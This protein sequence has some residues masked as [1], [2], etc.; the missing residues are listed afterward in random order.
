MSDAERR[1]PRQPAVERGRPGQD[2]AAGSAGG[3]I[4]GAGAAG[5]PGGSSD[6]TAEPGLASDATPGPGCTLDGLLARTDRID[7]YRARLEPARGS[8][9]PI[10]A[11]FLRAASPAAEEIARFDAER[12]MIR[13][14][15]VDGVARLAS[16]TKTLSGRPA[17]ALEAVPGEQLRTFVDG[18]PLPL[19]R[20]LSIAI[21]MTAI[22]G[23]LHAAGVTHKDLTPDRFL[24]D[25]RDS[26]LTLIDLGRATRLSRERLAPSGRAVIDGRPAYVSPE[27]TGRMNRPLDHRTDFYS[28][29][30]CFFEML[31]G[32]VPFELDDPLEIVHGHIARRPARV[33]TLNPDVPAAVG[34]I[35]ARLLEKSAHDRYQSA[36]GLRADLDRCRTQLVETHRVEPF[37]LGQDDVSTVL[38]IPDQL[39]GRDREVETLLAAFEHIRAGGTDFILV[40]GRSGI[41]KT[42]LVGEIHRP[43]A[44][45][46]GH[47]VEGRFDPLGRN[48]PY[49]GWIGAFTNLAHSLLMESQAELDAWRARLAGA[50]ATNGRVVTA[51]IPDLRLVVGPQPDV[52]NLGPSEM[53]NR[54]QRVFGEIVRALATPERPLVVF[55]DDLQWADQASLAL[56]ELLLA[57]RELAHVLIVGAY[58]DNELAPD[59]LLTES[60]ARIEK[61]GRP[62]TTIKVGSLRVGDVA[63]LL[64]DTLH[65]PIERTGE[66]ARLVHAKTDGNPWFIAGLLEAMFDSGLLEYSG[67]WQWDLE[68]VRL[69]PIGDDIADLMVGRIAG[70][71]PATM[72]VLKM[73]ACTGVEFDLDVVALA[74]GRSVAETIADLQPAFQAGI[75]EGSDRTGRFIHDRVSEATYNLISAEEREDLHH[76]IG[77]TLLT[78]AGGAWPEDLVFR[79]AEQFNASGSRLT[80]AERPIAFQANL[81]AGRRA[82]ASAAFEAA[83]RF[84]ARAAELLPENAWELDYA[85]TLA[86]YTDW[87]EAAYAAMDYG[88]AEELFALVLDRAAT[89][90]DRIRIHVA[91]IEYSLASMR[92]EEALEVVVTVIGELGIPFVP[93]AEIDEAA[94]AEQLAQFMANLGDRNPAELDRLPAAASPYKE[95]IEVL[96]SADPLLWL[97]YPG[98][99]FYGVLQG[100]NLSMEHGVCGATAGTLASLGSILCARGQVELGTAICEA[101]LRLL[102]RFDEPYR[103]AMVLLTYHNFVACWKSP[104]RQSVE[105]LLAEYYEAA[106]IG[107]NLGAANLIRDH[108]TMRL[109]SGEE[110]PS[111]AAAFDQFA[112]PFLRLNQ[113]SAA[114]TFSILRQATQVLCGNAPDP[115][116]LEGEFWSEARDLPELWRLRFSVAIATVGFA[117]LLI[118]SV[119]GDFG[120]ALEWVTRPGVEECRRSATG[121]YMEFVSAG[122]TALAYLRGGGTADER[123]EEHLASA[124]AIAARLRTA[125]EEYPPNFLPLYAL[126]AAEIARVKD[127]PWTAIRHY[128]QAIAAARGQE[129]PHLEGLANELAGLFWLDQGRDAYARP[130]LAAALSAYRRWGAR[131]KVAQ[132]LAQHPWLAAEARDAGESGPLDLRTVVKASQAISGEIELDRLLARLLQITIENAGAG[133]G[134]LLLRR[135]KSLIVA[136]EASSE[137]RAAILTSAPLESRTDVAHSIV[138][139]VVRSG[140]SVLLD[141]AANEGDFVADP[142]IAARK[143][144]SVLC[145]PIAL[146]GAL[147][148]VVYLENNL[149]AGAFGPDRL[150]VLEILCAQAAISLE[151]AR[152]YAERDRAA[153]ALRQSEEKFRTLVENTA[154][155]VFAMDT[156]GCF[157]YISPAI[158]ALSGY[159]PAEVVGRSFREFTLPEE[160]ARVASSFAAALGGT[161][162]PI[163]F[164]GLA[165]DGR[166]VHIRVSG[167]PQFEDGKPV[168]FTGIFTDISERRELQEQLLQAMKMESIGRLAGGVAHDF[169][170]LLTAILGNAELAMLELPPDAEAREAIAEIAKAGQRASSLTRQ[171]LAFASKQIVAP[172]RL[173]LSTVVSDS[174]R[175]LSRLLGE[176]IEI[177]TVLDPHLA[178][179]EAD[180]GQME[181]LL[182]NLTINARDA[183]PNGGHLV[184]ETRNALVEAGGPG[185]SSEV[186]PGP[187][188][189]LTV[190]DTGE[191]MSAET[192]SH[193]FEPF[194]TTKEAGKG[195]GLGLATCHGIV[196]QN[197][198]H[199]FVFSE[200]G[201]GSTFRIM[202][203]TASREVAAAGH[204][205]TPPTSIDGTETILV[206]E[207]EEQVR[208]LAVLGLRAH[209]YTVIEAAGG[210]QALKIVGRADTRLDLVVSDVVMPGMGGLE[211]ERRLARIRPAL[212]LI[213]ASGH[214]ETLV[215]SEQTGR[216]G[217]AFVQKPFTPEQLARKVREVLDATAPPESPPAEG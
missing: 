207:D 178:A 134:V 21:E 146:G 142:S 203:P 74:R 123:R 31:T 132:M 181:Q 48:I 86:L 205:Q 127:E 204:E 151:N 20:F 2:G 160:L 130:H 133:R 61:S 156:E 68:R 208:R 56:L 122:C 200:P 212:P 165:R 117:K 60:L 163:E 183:M 136:A 176:D 36:A 190:T 54:F 93:P 214:A 157:T 112:G 109:Q 216:G 78:A 1:P 198:G 174:E 169:N 90:T 191:G 201:L 82:R 184:I 77:R 4:G 96:A 33:E 217:V 8:A 89:L 141:D 84:C 185:G 38:R 138:N 98:A 85:T 7:V 140:H 111:V 97:A 154:D 197:R 43:V 103:R 65:C 10:L 27:Q 147:L 153:E 118:A 125:A 104:R 12:E 164:R 121:L 180:P 131:P 6:A 210:A 41:G 29:G 80:T 19:G 166:V 63:H 5:R 187:W 3:R 91:Q 114:V 126:V 15:K 175:M 102:A 28:L 172:V 139:Y 30:I 45:R 70:L 101:G 143:P 16:A 189:V 144:R 211:L 64:A 148:G 49:S 94:T 193:I 128:N 194:F 75:V 22:V 171:L 69:A 206:V 67:G 18:R 59:H 52:P 137:E 99:A 115:L 9:T 145:L 47:F 92:F 71:P 162:A 24:W 62:V 32:H 113:P 46:R 149:A 129:F 13:S 73:A 209:G 119:M 188:V 124:E 161:I 186:A 11:K 105:P 179:V 58:R 44:T 35:V 168:G 152:L 192:M 42:A 39:Y 76:A 37:Q 215:A 72:A 50:L 100:A 26:R 108:L 88:R 177:T 116:A 213:L 53:Q 182:V 158:E 14:L 40:A 155:V 110:L 66:L 202:L 150:E 51:V 135:G 106:R 196:K 173:S 25:E 55:L 83:S 34:D 195:T 81:Q 79:I 87:A 23:R 57:D 199:I 17:I 95:A 170:N 167:R 159:M 107:D 120:A